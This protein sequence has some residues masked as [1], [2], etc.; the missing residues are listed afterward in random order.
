[1]AARPPGKWNDYE[2]RVRGQDYTV[3]LNGQQ[4]TTFTDT[5]PGR[6]MPTTAEVPAY[7]GLQAHTGRVWFR[8]IRISVI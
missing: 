5:D 8:R 2:I 1:M 7:L 3:L 6:G 4:A